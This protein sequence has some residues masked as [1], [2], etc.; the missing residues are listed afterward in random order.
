MNWNHAVD[1]NLVHQLE[2]TLKF[3]AKWTTDEQ[4]LK[5]MILTPCLQTIL[6]THVEVQK[7]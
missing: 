6:S 1:H 3:S 7:L 5:A 4:R 2:A